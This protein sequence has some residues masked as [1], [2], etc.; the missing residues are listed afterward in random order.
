MPMTFT[1]AAPGSALPPP[2]RK[3]KSPL[4]PLGKFRRGCT[5]PGAYEVVEAVT[6]DSE[7]MFERAGDGTW[8]T[9]HLPT[10][11]VVKTGLRD[12]RACRAYAGSGRAARDLERIQAESTE[13]GE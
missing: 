6:A 2:A 8:M 4:A 10:E 3:P 9:G 1:A 12:L 5:G 11:T 7:W 13:G